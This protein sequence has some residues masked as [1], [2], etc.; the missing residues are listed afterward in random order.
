MFTMIVRQ[1][2]STAHAARSAACFNI[3]RSPSCF[4]VRN[5]T[6]G[7]PGPKKGGPTIQWIRSTK[8]FKLLVKSTVY[9]V[10]SNEN[11][12]KWFYWTVL[13]FIL[14]A[15]GCIGQ[16]QIFKMR[17]WR[18]GQSIMMTSSQ[19]K[20]FGVD[21]KQKSADQIMESLYSE[22]A[23]TDLDDWD[24]VRHPR[25]EE[26][27]TIVEHVRREEARKMKVI[28]EQVKEQLEELEGQELP[29]E[30]FE[31][32]FDYLDPEDE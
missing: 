27:E 15:A 11:C 14:L 5:V 26:P 2:F 24:N 29:E 22:M 17:D 8:V 30:E 12:Q 4:N 1:G 21:T 9:K 23:K 25:K 13:G 32:S 18:S 20:N 19:M 28:E 10:L 3:G 16:Q 31:Y 6:F 7:A